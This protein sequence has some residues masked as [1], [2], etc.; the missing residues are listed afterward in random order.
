MRVEDQMSLR[1]CFR[2]PVPRLLDVAR[3]LDAAVSAHIAGKPDL[4]A[5]LFAL[6]DDPEAREW[7]ESIWGK[8]SIYVQLRRLPPAET[9]AKV[10]ARMPTKAQMVQLH[11]RDGFHCRFCGLPVIRPEVRKMAAG[12]YPSVVSWGTSNAS[13]HAGFQALWAQYDHV[14]PHSCGGTNDLSNLVVTCAPCNFGKMSYRLE[15]I[16][17]LD[18]RDFVPVSSRWDGLER[19]LACA[20]NNSFKP[21]PLR[22][23]A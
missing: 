23:S 14:V 4:A 3:Y 21:K 10:A 11:A 20:S 15:E 5:E 18:P 9:S 8:G 6:A 17:L 19:L 2:D 7:T 22:G 13:Q 16:G 12:L 1:R